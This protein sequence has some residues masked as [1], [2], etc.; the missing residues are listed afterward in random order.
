MD[1]L[2]HLRD[3]IALRRRVYLVLMILGLA[4]IVGWMMSDAERILA[5]RTLPALAP[6]GN[7]L[8]ALTDGKAM[9]GFGAYSP[10]G[11]QIAFMRDG[12]IWLMSTE[13]K[14][15]RQL[16]RAAQMWDAVP[17]WRPDGKQIAF[18]RVSMEGD[19]ALV[20]AVDPESGKEKVLTRETEP[21]GH[22]AWDPAGKLLY[23][24]T[25]QRL[26]RLEAES[27]KGI[28]MHTVPE[29]WDL[30][31][32]GLVITPDG[33]KAIFGAGPRLG[34][35]VQYNLQQITLAKPT[36]ERERLTTGGGIMPV[37]DKAGKLLAYR[38]PRENSGIYVMDLARHSTR[39]VV[40]DEGRALY[41]HPAFSPDGKRLL[42]SRLLVG[43]TG[44]GPD[45]SRFTSH[46][47]V[48][49]LTPSGGN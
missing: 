1:G 31:A 48:H 47:Y 13:G 43:T 25:P 44:G 16:T 8:T 15:A 2:Y 30:Q 21:V 38:S 27:G 46:L 14:N 28:V 4:G 18:A 49:T 36:Q 20:V 5:D 45:G 41:F 3:W 32:G 37:M 9:D 40:A 22:V 39:Q 26:M 42:I 19:G 24:T 34:R 29:D 33:K 12:H 6:T 35:N 11:R 7:G 10:D 17:A 23:Y